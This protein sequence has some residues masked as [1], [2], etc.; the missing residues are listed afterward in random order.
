MKVSYAH[1]VLVKSEATYQENPALSTSTDGIYVPEA[2]T[3]TNER[4]FNGERRAQTGGWFKGVRPTGRKASGSIVTNPRGAGAAYSSASV[5]PLDVHALLKASGLTATRNGTTDWVYAPTSNPDS[6]TSAA[7]Q[8]YYHG[9]MHKVFGVYSDF[10]IVCDGVGVPKFTFNWA[11]VWDNS[12]YADATVPAIT[13]DSTV[14]PPVSESMT[15]EIGDYV[16]PVVRRFR[17]A[18]AREMQDRQSIAFAGGY[19]GA[20][21]L[22]RSPVLELTIEKTALVGNPYHTSGGLDPIRLWDAATSI[23]VN[24]TCGTTQYNRWKVLCP[25]AQLASVTSGDDN[26]IATWEL[27]FH[28]HQSTPTANDDFTVKFD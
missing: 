6:I 25:Q 13:I 12:A 19:Y 5:V 23:D 7:L 17:F 8:C 9:E 2:P 20:A 15:V 18:Q 16:L 3:F 4:L 27:V 28:P 26:G 21:M 11:G 24:V 22:N 1:G 10:E 14:V